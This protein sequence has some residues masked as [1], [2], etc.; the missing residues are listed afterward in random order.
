MVD[1]RVFDKVNITFRFVKENI[2]KNEKWPLFY[3]NRVTHMR[4]AAAGGTH[5]EAAIGKG[6]LRPGCRRAAE[7]CVELALNCR[8]AATPHVRQGFSAGRMPG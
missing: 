8:T 7:S 2:D 3:E 4:R 6:R 1:P 5:S